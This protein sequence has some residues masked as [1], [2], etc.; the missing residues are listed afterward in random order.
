MSTKQPYRAAAS[1]SLEKERGRKTETELE[2]KQRES[3]DLITSAWTDN[4]DEKSYLW[5]SVCVF[6]CEIACPCVNVHARLPESQ[7]ELMKT[8]PVE[9][10]PEDLRVCEWE[11]RSELCSDTPSVIQHVLLCDLV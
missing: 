4:S 2:W 11:K 9:C 1:F 7:D 6:L 8:I 5:L 10:A 3:L